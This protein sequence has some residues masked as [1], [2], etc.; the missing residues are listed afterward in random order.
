[1]SSQEI[2]GTIQKLKNLESQVNQFL[3]E[4]MEGDINAFVIPEIKNVALAANLPQEFVDGIK[5]V[6]TG[7]N[8][9]K[10]INTW[11][12][13]ELPLAKWFNYG[14]KQHWIQPKKEGGVLAWT[15]KAG[16]N[17]RAIFFQGGAKVGDILFSKGHFVSGLPRTE[18]M[19]IGIALGMRAL[20]ANVQNRTN[21]KLR[22]VAEQ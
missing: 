6:K 18:V 12:T 1:M 19:E 8:E 21:A 13:S 15:A 7:K 9:G 22:E 4:S 11:G 14:T 10:I 2:E 17:P 16:R 20:T 3:D 5:F